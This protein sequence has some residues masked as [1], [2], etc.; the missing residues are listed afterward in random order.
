MSVDDL[1]NA[2]T[3]EKKP[4]LAENIINELAEKDNKTE[5]IQQ[6]KIPEPETQPEQSE[7]KK[8]KIV[9][10]GELPDYEAIRR[11]EMERMRLEHERAGFPVQ[12]DEENGEINEVQEEIIP[13]ADIKNVG[14]PVET[15][16]AAEAMPVETSDKPEIESEPEPEKK[17]KKK[18]KKSFFSKRKKTQEREDATE[19]PEI[20]PAEEPVSDDYEIKI[21]DIFDNSS[22]VENAASEPEN[23]PVQ[24]D[25][26]PEETIQDEPVNEENSSAVELIDAALEAINAAS[27]PETPVEEAVNEAENISEAV[28]E[29]EE[30]ES[31]VSSLI[32]G[33]RENAASA[34]ADL[35]KPK[36][37]T[38]ELPAEPVV[39]EDTEEKRTILMKRKRAG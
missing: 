18:V 31:R 23:V 32:D 28:E 30:N 35:D 37:E 6:E 27:E 39:S 16:E 3:E 7:T 8:K 17:T 34:I 21:D 10:T 22:E 15:Y 19:K 36:E 38:A 26:V 5:E 4:S 20:Q 33:I 1:L 25:A 9:I 11:Q 12:P 2:L 13:E 14:E 29:N 24:D